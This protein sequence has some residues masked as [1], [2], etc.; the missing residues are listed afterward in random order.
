VRCTLQVMSEGMQEYP[1]LIIFQDIASKSSIDWV[2][3]I[4]YLWCKRFCQVLGTQCNINIA[5]TSTNMTSTESGT[6]TGL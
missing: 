5:Y 1:N 3:V 6:P 4:A 2:T